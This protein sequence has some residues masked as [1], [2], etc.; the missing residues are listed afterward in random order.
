MP[1]RKSYS[2]IENQQQ[3]N[4]SFCKRKKH[5]VKKL[6]E[7]GILTDVNIYFM[8]FDREKQKVFEYRSKLEFDSNVVQTLTDPA[9]KT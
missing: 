9:V 2:L 4:V 3:R 7:L 8:I 1:Q 6:V 5:I